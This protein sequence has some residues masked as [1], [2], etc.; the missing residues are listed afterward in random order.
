MNTAWGDSYTSMQ[1]KIGDST[2]IWSRNDKTRLRGSNWSASLMLITLANWTRTL[3]PPPVSVLCLDTMS[4]ARSPSYSRYSAGSSWT[5]CY[6]HCSTRNRLAPQ[7]DVWNQ[8]SPYWSRD[9]TTAGWLTIPPRRTSR[10]LCVP[11]YDFC[12][13]LV[14]VFTA[15]NSN[16]SGRSKHVDGRHLK[17]RDGK[18]IEWK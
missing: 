2:T 16:S 5:H 6:E 1:K 9:S 15:A 18:H 4:H 10:P 11:Y 12:D 7:Y 13:N 3:S 14:S 17:I 8:C